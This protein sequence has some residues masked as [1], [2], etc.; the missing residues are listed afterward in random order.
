[1]GCEEGG[2]ML[3]LIVIPVELYHDRFAFGCSLLRPLD[4]QLSLYVFAIASK[5]A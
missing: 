2:K 1:M 3:T 4:V 5:F